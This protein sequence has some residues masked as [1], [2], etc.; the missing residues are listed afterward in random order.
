MVLMMT[1]DHLP[2]YCVFVR[3]HGGKHSRLQA[4]PC[5]TGSLLRRR[6][7]PPTHTLHSMPSYH[8]SPGPLAQPPWPRTAPPDKTL[9]SL[10]P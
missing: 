2:Q 10:F 7:T 9:K 5:A 6:W 1:D 3:P 4:T 8:R